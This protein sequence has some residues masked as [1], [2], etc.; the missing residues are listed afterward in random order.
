MGNCCKHYWDNTSELEP[1]PPQPMVI[2][3]SLP[4]NYKDNTSKIEGPS[5]EPKVI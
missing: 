3:L 1:P 5:A 4:N 2:S